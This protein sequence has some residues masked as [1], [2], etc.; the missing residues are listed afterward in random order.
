MKYP[1]DKMSALEKGT[2]VVTKMVK[3]SKSKKKC[4]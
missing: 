2:E 1:K 3:K 4:K